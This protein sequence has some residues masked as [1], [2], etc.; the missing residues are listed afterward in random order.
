M[1]IR[2]RANRVGAQVL[3]DGF[4]P[5]MAAAAAAGPQPDLAQR[6]IRIVHRHQQ[7]LQ[8]HPIKCHHRPDRFAARIHVRLRLAQQHPLAASRS[9]RPGGL[10]LLLVGPVRPPAL[11]Q[12]F[13][14]QKPALCRVRAYSAPGLP[15]PTM[16]YRFSMRGA[17]RAANRAAEPVLAK[18]KLF[19]LVPPHSA[20]C[21]LLLASRRLF[22]E[23]QRR[24]FRHP[25]RSLFGT[26]R[27]APFRPF[28]AAP[29]S[30]APLA[31]RSRL[32]RLLPSSL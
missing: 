21:I 32:L 19:L 11:R 25:G 26:F 3:L 20:C 29:F 2:S 16:R 14:H 6:Q 8:R 13:D 28:A 23:P 15:N 22:P 17:C 7:S 27:A 18:G 5:M 4:Q 9:A 10:E 31:G 1:P 12:P 30:A 24:P